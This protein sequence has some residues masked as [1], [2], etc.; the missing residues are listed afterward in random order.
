[1]LLFILSVKAQ[2]AKVKYNPEYDEKPIHFG[3]SLGINTM[4]FGFKRNVTGR[5][6]D[7]LYGDVSSLVPGFQVNIISD[8]RLGEYFN[9]RF[10]PGIAFG[11]RNIYF[12]VR[13]PNNLNS[14]IN[15]NSVHTEK[16]ESSFLDFPLSVKYKAKRLN[17][18]RPYLLGG[19][20]IRYD[21]AAKSKYDEQSENYIILKPINYYCEMGFGIDYYL[22][23]FKF[24]TEVKLS[25]G[26][27]DV[28][29]HTPPPGNDE[30][31][32]A[33]KKL[34]SQ[35]FMLSFHFE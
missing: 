22:P 16:L 10:L 2:E 19:I 18:Y 24:S 28:L 15:A 34:T 7:T 31:V 35:V 25:V 4:D 9:L 21:L 23:Y 8:Y 6:P 27:N 20:N 1:M 3:F 29:N 13:N 26:L 11:Q 33:I 32:N 12:Y 5:G 30:Y 17:N 14:Q